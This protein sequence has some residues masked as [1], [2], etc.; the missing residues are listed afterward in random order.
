MAAAIMLKI[1]LVALGEHMPSWVK[2][3]VDEYSKRLQEYAKLNIIQI[4]LIKRQ[5]AGQLERILQQE[6]LKIIQAIPKSSRVIA[7]DVTGK[8]FC[9]DQLALKLNQLSQITSHLCFIIAGPEGFDSA[10]LMQ[11]DERWSLSPLTLPHPLVR[12]LVLESLYRGFAINHHHPY[13]RS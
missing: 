13:H 7:Y 6:S 3:A 11:S 12:V 10:V 8:S 2:Q 5:D 1:T 4:P 9:S